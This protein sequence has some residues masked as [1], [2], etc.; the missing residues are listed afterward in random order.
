MTHRDPYT[1][2]MAE[3]ESRIETILEWPRT[4]GDALDND[5]RCGCDPECPYDDVMELDRALAILAVAC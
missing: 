3:L 4:Y 5:P 1:L 2:T